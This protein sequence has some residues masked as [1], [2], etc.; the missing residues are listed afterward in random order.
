LG[1]KPEHVIIDTHI[2]IYTERTDQT[3]RNIHRAREFNTITLIPTQ[4]CRRGKANLLPLGDLVLGLLQSLFAIIES[5]LQLRERAQCLEPVLCDGVSLV[6]Q[7]SLN[8]NQKLL[9]R[10]LVH[11]SRLRHQLCI[12]V[13]YVERRRQGLQNIS[14]TQRLPL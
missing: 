1:L 7:G 12:E 11:G 10:S 6:V 14:S 8:V 9:E 3:Y 2:E 13:A 4:V 5:L